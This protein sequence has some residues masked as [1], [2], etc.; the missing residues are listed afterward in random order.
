M[1]EHPDVIL[2]LLFESIRGDWSQ[3]IPE[4]AEAIID[5]LPFTNF[6]EKEEM[7]TRMNVMSIQWYTNRADFDGRDFARNGKYTYY[8]LYKLYTNTDELYKSKLLKRSLS[9]GEGE[10]LHADWRIFGGCHDDVMQLYEEWKNAQT[11]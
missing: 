3:G 2:Y 5:I 7:E 10:T 8:L 4:R 11:Q 1:P 6:E 9:D